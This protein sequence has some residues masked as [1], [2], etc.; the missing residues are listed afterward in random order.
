M[1]DVGFRIAGGA[2]V[3]QV[4]RLALLAQ[5]DNFIFGPTAFIKVGG[6]VFSGW[7]GFDQAIEEGLEFRLFDAD[8]LEDPSGKE[9]DWCGARVGGAERAKRGHGDLLVGLGG[10]G[11]GD[12]GEA[13][14]Q[15]GRSPLGGEGGEVAA[16][17]VDDARGLVDRSW[18]GLCSGCGRVMAGAKNDAG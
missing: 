11:D 10:V 14:G 15:A 16:R 4:P 17:H 13:W 2:C 8:G 5:D 6:L 3:Q 1:R 12:A 9:E 7:S 18:T